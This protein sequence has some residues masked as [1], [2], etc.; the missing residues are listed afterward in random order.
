MNQEIDGDHDLDEE[1]DN[2]VIDNSDDDND[3]DDNVSGADNTDPD[4]DVEVD[5]ND[6]EDAASDANDATVADDD[7]EAEIDF[8]HDD[9][10]EP[11]RSTRDVHIPTRYPETDPNIER[12]LHKHMYFQ[13]VDQYQNIEATMSSKQYGLNAGL[14]VFKDDGLEAVSNEIKNNLHGRGVIEPVKQHMVTGKIRKA[15]L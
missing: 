1:I 2:T 14:K 4:V 10:T 6:D 11:R 12:V 15:S 5:V 13:A 8:E 7:I 3:V 9:E